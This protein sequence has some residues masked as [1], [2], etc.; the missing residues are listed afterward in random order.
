MKNLKKL[1]ARLKSITEE[2]QAQELAKII[3]K[4]QEEVFNLNRK[5]LM[6]GVDSDGLSLGEYANEDYARMKK[7]L[8]PRGVIDLRLNGDF[9]GEFFLV[10]E[11]PLIIWS[12]DGK[13]DFLVQRFGKKIFGLT[14][15][16][17]KV[18]ITGYVRP[19][20]GEYQKKLLRL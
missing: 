7:T 12:Y 9:H 15:D 16:N 5:Q 11:V 17:K 19:E 4:Y 20:F 14:E 6:E 8:N 2:E 13:T 1:A 18:F 10:S 3:D